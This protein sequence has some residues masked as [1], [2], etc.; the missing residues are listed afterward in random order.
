MMDNFIDKQNRITLPILSYTLASFFV[1]F[2]SDLGMTFVLFFLFLVTT[3][4]LT[5]K[6]SAIITVIS[7]SFFVTF[8]YLSLISLLDWQLP[9]DKLQEIIPFAV[10]LSIVVCTGVVVFREISTFQLV[11]ITKLICPG[12]NAIYAVLS[13]FRVFPVMFNI[14]SK[15]IMAQKVRG[16]HNNKLLSIKTYLLN[17]LI[18]FFEFIFDF[19][20]QLESVDIKKIDL[21]IKISAK[22][23]YFIAYLYASVVGIYYA[24]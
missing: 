1:I 10:G 18:N 14:S 24:K 8:F 3:Y 6:I 22:S 16:M 9:F 15:T 21:I 13:G 4:L 5:N 2:V 7:I 17:M 20:N 12:E 19:G 11:K 23:I